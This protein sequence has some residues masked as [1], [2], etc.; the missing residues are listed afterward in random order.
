MIGPLFYRYVCASCDAGR[1][2][3]CSAAPPVAFWRC[4]SARTD[5]ASVITSVTKIIARD[6]KIYVEE[7]RETSHNCIQMNQRVA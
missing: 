4:A 1:D 2:V 7:R 5:R 6:D 3:S